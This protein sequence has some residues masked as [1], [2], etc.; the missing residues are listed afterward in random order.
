MRS[1][2]FPLDGGHGEISFSLSF[3]PPTAFLHGYRNRMDEIDASVVAMGGS[4]SMDRRGD[5]IEGGYLRACV[6]RNASTRER[7]LREKKG[8]IGRIHPVLEQ[9]GGDVLCRHPKKKNP[10]HTSW[11]V[12]NDPRSLLGCFASNAFLRSRSL[13][14]EGN[15]EE[16]RMKDEVFQGTGRVA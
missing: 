4:G 1:I 9:V 16:I 10:S 11:I 8:G 15:E 7:G 5:E 3:S 13:S 2:S 6:R 14:F 12:R